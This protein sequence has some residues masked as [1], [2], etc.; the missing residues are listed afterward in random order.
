MIDL[1]RKH[2]RETLRRKS[3]GE[4]SGEMSMDEYIQTFMQLPS[5]LYDTHSFMHRVRV[6]TEENAM[7]RQNNYLE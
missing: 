5:T 2:H 3:D 4:S 7:K 1:V 6:I